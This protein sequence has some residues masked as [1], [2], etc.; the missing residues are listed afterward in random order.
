MVAAQ[1]SNIVA[2]ATFS[3]NDTYRSIEHV[4]VT[5]QAQ[6]GGIGTKVLEAIERDAREH[7][8]L[9][10]QL[11][12]VE[13]ATDLVRLYTKL[14]YRVISKEPP[15]HGRDNHPRVFMNKNLSPLELN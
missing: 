1:G 5:P 10:L 11:D 4:G 15:K 6:G 13:F 9:S 8:L 12:T 7:G 14:G 3:D 2:A